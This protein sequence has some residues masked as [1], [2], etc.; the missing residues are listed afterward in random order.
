MPGRGR[1]R[2]LPTLVALVDDL[3]VERDAAGLLSSALEHLS[4]I[5]I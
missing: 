5:H 4:L 3:G 2:L 1:D